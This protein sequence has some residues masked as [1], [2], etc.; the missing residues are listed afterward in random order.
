MKYTVEV[1]KMS[2]LFYS[3][4]YVQNKTDTGGHGDKHERSYSDQD[5]S[6]LI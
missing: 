4:Q 6:L 5:L 2:V 3:V 1:R